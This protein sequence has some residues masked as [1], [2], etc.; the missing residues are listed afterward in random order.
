MKPIALIVILAATLL[1]AC[2]GSAVTRPNASPTAQAVV[3]AYL[4][5]FNR[6]D[7]DAAAAWL[8]PDLQWLAIDGGQSKLE[9][10]GREA[11]RLWLQAYFQ[12]TPDVRSE[13]DSLARGAQRVAVYECVSWRGSEGAQRRCAHGLYE[14]QGGLIQ[15]VWYWPAEA[16]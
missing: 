10:S 9:A 1:S 4:A 2:G 6:H 12:S 3:T 5:A 16:S 15:R 7:A 8:A 13:I 11:M 14:V